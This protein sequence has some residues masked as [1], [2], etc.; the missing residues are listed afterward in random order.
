MRGA[1]RVRCE[2]ILELHTERAEAQVSCDGVADVI[3]ASVMLGTE[4]GMRWGP[5]GNEGGATGEWT[6]S[7][8]GDGPEDEVFCR[9]FLKGGLRGTPSG[10]YFYLSAGSATDTSKI[11]KIC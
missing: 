7:L 1:R 8:K 10:I 4:G 3:P 2:Y 9:K 5:D 6:A 11:L